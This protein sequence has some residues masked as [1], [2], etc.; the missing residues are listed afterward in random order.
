[1][2]N[3]KDKLKQKENTFDFII[4][5]LPTVDYFN[6]TLRLLCPEGKYVMVGI[7]PFNHDLKLDFKKLIF[8]DNILV[9]SFNG[10]RQLLM[11]LLNF[12]SKII[13][14]LKLKN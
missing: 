10:S 11:R 4:N 1:M 2:L 3:D 13:F 5:T 12:A 7:P 9:G 14:T 6:E 8:G